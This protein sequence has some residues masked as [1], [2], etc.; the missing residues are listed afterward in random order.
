MSHD[1]RHAGERIQT[2]WL[3]RAIRRAEPAAAED[4][5]DW[6]FASVPDNT[7][8]RRLKIAQLLRAH[9]FSTADALIAQWLLRRPTD[10]A[11]SM[12]RARS[13]ER[14]GRLRHADDEIRF[15]LQRRPHHVAAL[16][17]AADVAGGLGDHRRAVA[18]LRHAAARRPAD[19]AIRDQLIRALIASDRCDEA[20]QELRTMNQPA[21]LLEALVRRAQGRWLDAAAILRA[22]LT[23]APPGP[24]AQSMQVQLIDLLE[25]IGDAAGLAD[26]VERVDDESPDVATRAASALLWLGAFP[27][28]AGRAAG[29]VRRRR[30]SWGA[31]HTLL[32][33]AALAGRPRL[34]RSALRRLQATRRGIDRRRMAAEW[35]KG[36][37]AR[38]TLEQR[39][40]RGAGADP[41]RSI[42]QPL[43]Q[44]A[45]RTL[46]EAIRTPGADLADAD[47][48][49]LRMHRASCLAAMGR[50]REA[51][52]GLDVAAP[53]DA[54]IVPASSRAPARRAA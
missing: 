22:A 4:M 17:L 29:V 13:L 52:A 40:A 44:D 20:E 39:C 37:L 53:L 46:E 35:R 33:A 38:L 51:M 47:R 54:A 36:L 32:V 11:I 10:P 8:V 43:L 19:P 7:H 31:L 45:A 41:S 1:G 5:I 24:R 2:A 28:A 14:Q 25:Q 34:A 42:L 27:A 18:H 50:P 9:D 3:L 48:T 21:P 23:A 12:L 15:V 6:V 26:L 30:R 49:V 16:L